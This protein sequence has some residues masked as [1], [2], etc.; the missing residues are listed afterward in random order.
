MNSGKSISWTDKP[1]MVKQ[2]LD[3]L[4]DHYHI[5]STILLFI[6]IIIIIIQFGNLKTNTFHKKPHTHEAWASVDINLGA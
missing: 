4:C 5:I 3:Y 2:E 6:T 1:N